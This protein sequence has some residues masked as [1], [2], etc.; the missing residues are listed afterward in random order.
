MLKTTILKKTSLITLLFF[1][2]FSAFTDFNFAQGSQGD[3][4]LDKA[5]E[6]YKQGDYAG[7][8]QLLKEFID[9]IKAIAEQ[10]RSA[11]QAFYLMAKIY[12]SQGDD[13][14]ADENLKKTFENYP[15]LNEHEEDLDFKDRVERIRK[16]IAEESYQTAVVCFEK[17]NDAASVNENLRNC[18]TIF[19]DFKDNETNTVPEN[20]KNKKAKIKE[21]VAG[22]Y[23]VLARDH[24]KQNDSDKSK[25]YLRKVFILYP[26]FEEVEAKDQIPEFKK[27]KAES[28]YEIAKHHFTNK[29]TAKCDEYLD[30]VFK[31]DK[32]FTRIEDDKE[33]KAKV[34]QAKERIEPP[35]AEQKIIEKSIIKKKKF[36]W[37]LVA[38]GVVVVG[39]LIYLATK[40]SKKILTV[41]MGEGV[42]GNPGSG[43]YT[44]KKGSS[45]NY[46]YNVQSGYTALV[47][48]LDGNPVASSG[49][50]K[51]D[52]PHTL[53]V[54]ASKE[55]SLTVNKGAGING[56][57]DGGTI[58]CKT[59]ESLYYSYTL[60]SGYSELFVTIDGNSVPSSG[61]ITMNNN[62]TL[63][64]S[65]SK[66]YVLVITK[67]EG[68]IGTPGDGTVNCKDG[69]M[70]YYSYTVQDGYRELSVIL[71]GS[72]IAD[73]GTI[74][75]N[76]NHTLN[77]TA[78]K[79]YTLTVTRGIGVTGQPDTGY[80][81]YKEGDII[82]YN[83][84]LQSGYKNLA[85]KL[86]GSTVAA[87]GNVVMNTNHILMATTSADDQIPTISITN[88]ANMAT[89]SGT[90]AISANATDD[91]GITKVEFYID[92][93]YK[94]ADSSSPYQ[95]SW[96]TTKYSNS[97][98][99]IKA[100]AYDTSNQINSQEIRVTTNNK[101][102]TVNSVKIK[103]TAR[104]AGTNLQ[105]TQSV[106]VDGHLKL[107]KTFDFDVPFSDVW[108]DSKKYYE[109]I[110]TSR[111]LGSM[112]IRQIADPNYG[113]FY[114]E[115]I[116][117]WHTLYDLEIVSYTYTGGTDPGTPLLSDRYIYL[118]VCPW[119]TTSP[120]WGRDQSYI[121]TIS[122]PSDLNPQK[123]NNKQEE[124]KSQ[125]RQNI[126]YKK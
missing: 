118:Y 35:T 24:V 44:Y 113:W 88:P 40:K 2:W 59:G 122:A 48:T 60:Q 18:F 52:A 85:A 41:T 39:A 80:H 73:S 102:G 98:H 87:T 70:V 62:H 69:D 20:F 64:V 96:D 91:K 93:V 34:V 76:G 7:S 99:K 6:R 27:F 10:K 120:G 67:G 19:P 46:N 86:D 103:I 33:F 84:S 108:E 110:T 123:A 50:L 37:V 92:G 101:V 82:T 21:E 31:T 74:L 115:S 38:A 26:D 126:L 112:E 61:T 30:K 11:A 16:K 9:Q 100:I 114:N 117:I 66:Q 104:F 63:T 106:Y 36:P 17:E 97:S 77:A 53:N 32:T 119:D 58:K 49:T 14:N 13:I 89:V 8:I 75:M 71:D 94:Q 5:K 90:V 22:S 95:Y 124:D 25:E 29:Q 79:E 45:I 1:I 23:Y 28:Y 83:Y 111:G 54:T 121:I 116:N 3:N 125:Y 81:K 78:Y 55:Y 51:M 109:S 4:R 15:A 42:S 56:L 105:T 107:N 68:V 65:A 57:P 47:V 72:L 43:T 12:H